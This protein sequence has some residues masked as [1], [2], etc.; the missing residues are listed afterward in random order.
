MQRINLSN[1]QIVALGSGFVEGLLSLK[2]WSIDHNS[3]TEYNHA[4]FEA[5]GNLDVLHSDDYLFCCLAALDASAC[6]PLPDALSS[7]Y[8]LMKEDVQRVFLWLFG[9]MAVL[10]NLSISYHMKIAKPTVT[11]EL[12]KHL[13]AADCLFGVYMLCIA[14]VDLYFRGIYIENAQAW[15]QSSF[16]TVRPLSYTIVVVNDCTCNSQF[17]GCLAT[18][19]S[20]GSVL[21]LLTIT[22]DRLKRITFPFSKS[23][24][25]IKSVKLALLLVWLLAALIVIIPLFPTDYFRGQYYS[26]Y[27]RYSL[28]KQATI[29]CHN[30]RSSVCV[31]IHITR[32]TPPGWEYSVAVTHGF[33][34]CAF[35]FMFFAYCYMYTQIRSSSKASGSGHKELTI[36]RKM[37]LIVLT[38][39]CCW[40]PINILGQFSLIN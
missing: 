14:S 34:F 40:I 37:T 13:A 9:L 3:I 27:V 11:S 17:L 36:A 16:C 32:E 29:L 7:C 35:L 31:S 28:C 38:D 21:I 20:E 33:N 22:C 23:N 24:L 8:D 5:M 26:R 19:S 39:F 30:Y 18:F 4:D 10:G 2:Q 25:T 6:L 15:K 1:N 12:T